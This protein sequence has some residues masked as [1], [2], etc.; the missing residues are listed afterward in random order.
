MLISFSTGYGILPAANA[1]CW[2]AVC[3]ALASNHVHNAGHCWTIH[4]A[5]VDWSLC[6][7]GFFHL[8]ASGGQ[9]GILP[10]GV[11]CFQQLKF[12]GV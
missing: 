6:L 10:Y 12:F 7:A 8:Y 9:G 11:S 3:G 2:T 4:E 5:G 1:F